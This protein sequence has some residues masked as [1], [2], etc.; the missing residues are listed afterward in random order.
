M[1][2]AAGWS[3][4]LIAKLDSPVAVF[5]VDVDGDG[6]DDIIICYNYGEDFINCNPN[7]G[8]IAWLENPG[9]DKQGQPI[10]EAWVKH[11]I[12]RWPAMH[13]LK[14]G[15]FTQRCD[16]STALQSSI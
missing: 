16:R 13:R 10:K 2:L 12:G 3:S 6:R 1:N 7:G 15:F 5:V 11:Y 8:Y 14:A 9:R 4:T